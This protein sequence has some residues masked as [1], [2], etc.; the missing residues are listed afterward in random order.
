[1]TQNPE[2]ILYHYRS[3]PFA[4][5]IVW[6]L[7]LRG[8]PYAECLQGM[9]MP[10]PDIEALGTKYRRI[11]IVVIGRN[12]YNDTRLILKKLE[13]LYPDYPQISA[14]STSSPDHTA[15]EKLL[16]FWTVDGL[17]SRAAQL[18][19]TNLPLMND[20][21]FT[22]DRE[23][24]TGRSWEKNS[25]AR[26][27][28]EA[29][30]ALRGA[31]EFMENTFFSDDRDWILKTSSPTLSDIEAVWPF[32]WL[33]TMPGAL[34]E[35]YISHQQFPKT[36]AWIA[37]FDK[38]TRLAAKKVPKARRLLGSEAI[39]IVSTS[40]FVEMD[41]IVDALD[42]TGLQKG[43]EV[44]VW[45]IDTGMNNKDKGTLVGLSSQEIIIES[46]TKDGVK[47]KIHTPR[48]GFRIRGI[49]SKGG[50]NAAKL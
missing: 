15:I 46:H 32:H 36:F 33:T 5:R 21:K 27:R 14:S 16:E 9:I 35:D 49:I 13:K 17:F 22:S 3:S 12:I 10:R 2:I 8:I 28:P 24:Y 48:H 45:P 31:F 30:A 37:R 25:L 44:E 50:G 47:I 1:M 19:P 38:T 43:Q 4:K 26:G 29:L 7:N 34:S 20:P 11:P 41:E 18:I 39:K 40:D 42:P 6:Y 23:N